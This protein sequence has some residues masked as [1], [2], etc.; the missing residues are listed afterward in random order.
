[1]HLHIVYVQ[2]IAHVFL[3]KEKFYFW[4]LGNRD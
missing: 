4:L 1:M 2:Y 3:R